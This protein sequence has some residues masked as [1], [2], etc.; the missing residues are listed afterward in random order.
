MK[1]IGKNPRTQRSLRKKKKMIAYTCSSLAW[2]EARMK[3][4]DSCLKAC[5][6]LHSRSIHGKPTN[7]KK[8]N[9]EGSAF[10]TTIE[11]IKEPPPF[12]ETIP[13]TKEQLEHLYKLFSPKMTFNPSSSLAQKVLIPLLLSV[14]Q[15]ITQNSFPVSSL[16]LHNVFHV[17]NL[18]CN[19]LSVSKITLDLMSCNI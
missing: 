1:M 3:G 15:K 13:F 2:V 16:T 4:K 19:L 11:E 6:L 14:V 7:L 17:P 12:A 18:S 10:Q 9:R 8:S 5:T